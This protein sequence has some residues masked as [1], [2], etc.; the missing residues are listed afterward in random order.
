M[1]LQRQC[2]RAHR[3]S[4]GTVGD[5]DARDDRAAHRGELG[6]GQRPVS[7]RQ[8]DPV[9]MLNETVNKI[10]RTTGWSQGKVIG[11]CVDTGV[12]GTDIV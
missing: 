11:T 8:R 10:G 4:I 1:P 12:S 7:D 5:V 2:I 3:A 6:E 9:P